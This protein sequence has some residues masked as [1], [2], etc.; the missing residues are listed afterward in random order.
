VLELHHRSQHIVREV[1]VGE[2]TFQLPDLL[3]PAGREVSTPSDNLPNSIS[4][5]SQ[6]S[7]SQCAGTTYAWIN[8]TFLLHQD[9]AMG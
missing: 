2:H 1:T 4:F 7:C 3:T 5:D 9:A 6:Y 8:S